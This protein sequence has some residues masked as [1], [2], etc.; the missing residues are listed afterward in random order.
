[1][2]ELVA[3]L[4]FGIFVGGLAIFWWLKKTHRLDTLSRYPNSYSPQ[5][6]E[7][8]LFKAGYLIVAKQPK[9][10][11]IT[12]VDGK[13]HLGTLEADYLVAKGK[14]KDMV[15]VKTGQVALD[16]L[17]PIFRRRLVELQT[18]FGTEALLLVDPEAGSIQEI[19]FR[20]PRERSIDGLFRVLLGVFIVFVIIGIIWMLVQLR[21]F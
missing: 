17:E 5:A 16:P 15:F 8:L 20:F 11:I 19:A 14:E 13:E 6:V 12:E 2:P 3:A 10:S 18:V 21:L 1:M 4:L 7:S 9:A